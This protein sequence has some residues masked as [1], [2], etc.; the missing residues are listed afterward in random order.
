MT[1]SKIDGSTVAEFDRKEWYDKTEITI[2]LTQCGT[3]AIYEQYGR[4]N[5]CQN[6]MSATN[7]QNAFQL[8]DK[9]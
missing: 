5:A 6:V 1:W 8:A 3:V 4:S 9:L 2:Y 7:E